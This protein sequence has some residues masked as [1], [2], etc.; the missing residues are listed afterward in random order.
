MEQEYRKLS[1]W[2][3]SAPGSL[4]TRSALEKDIEAD[5]AIVGAGYTGLWTAY[6]LRQI[7][8]S[9]NIVILEAEISGFGA[10]GRNGG[11]C[12]GTL[13]GMAGF[14]EGDAS[15]RAAGIR[16]QRAIFDTVAEVER[17]CENEAIDCDFARGGNVTFAMVPAHIDGLRSD[18][19]SWHELGFGEDDVRWLEAGECRRRV[20][21]E[22][23]LGGYY[24]AHCA[25]LHPARLVRGLA[26]SHPQQLAATRPWWW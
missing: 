25:S 9:L 7:D 4:K 16:L 20:G 3:D 11:W 17:V 15:Q 6:Y 13:A 14:L 26:A 12:L 18:V 22:R 5:I 21:S 8:P 24:L 19:A 2:H 10:S 23:N 1:Y